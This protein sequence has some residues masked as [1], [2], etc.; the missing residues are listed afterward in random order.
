[1]L[2]GLAVGDPTLVDHIDGDGLNNRRT[3][4][5]YA[6]HTINM[7]NRK[8][9]VNNTSGKSG[10]VFR[11]DHGPAGAWSAIACIDGKFVQKTFGCLKR[12]NDAARALAEKWRNDHE[13][14]CGITVREGEI[15]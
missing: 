3:N 1:M 2:M 6:D 13:I 7:R 12:G 9:N 5:R 14:K 4:I 10:V 11:A 15:A 8:R